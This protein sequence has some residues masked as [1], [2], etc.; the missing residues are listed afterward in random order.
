[1]AAAFARASEGNNSEAK[2]VITAITTNNSMIV[3]APTPRFFGI[4][5]FFG[6]FYSE[7]TSFHEFIPGMSDACI[8]TPE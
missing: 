8:K 1:L 6:S 2:I 7:L 5:L 3:K 4:Q